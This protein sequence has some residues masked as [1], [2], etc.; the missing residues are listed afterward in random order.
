MQNGITDKFGRPI[1][2]LRVS[3]TDRCNFRCPYCMPAE[4]YGEKYEF[5]PRQEL[6]TFEEIARLTRL[7][8]GL[9][10]TKIR[11]T[12]GEPLLRNGIERLTALIAGIDGAVDVTLTTN[13][14]LLAGKAQALKDAGLRR[15]TVSLD[16][17]DDDVFKAM[18]GRGYGTRR[19]LEGIRKAEEVGLLPIKIN[20]VVQR[21][22][23]D[24]TIVDLAR[25]F[26]GTG[27]IVRFI[28]YMDVGN[29]NGWKL[30]HVVPADEIVQGIDAELPWNPSRRTTG[31]RWHCGTGTP[32]AAAR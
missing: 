14:F 8:V 18:N 28:E 4:I 24:H 17:L 25:H 29:L 7:F 3:V 23:N 22:V 32:T 20:A 5:L 12:G 2:D 31:E 13:G 27:H 15:V 1:R 21:G 11:L 10:V 6:L 30:D 26:K 16:S 9:G 19:V